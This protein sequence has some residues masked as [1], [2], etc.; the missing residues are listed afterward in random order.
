MNLILMRKSDI[1]VIVQGGKQR[2]V[3]YFP[4]GTVSKEMSHI[5]NLRAW[6]GPTHLAPLLILDFEKKTS[7]IS[8]SWEI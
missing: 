1:I 8:S 4:Q 2:E 5:S 3:R 7:C 6:F